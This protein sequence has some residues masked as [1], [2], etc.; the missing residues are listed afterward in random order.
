MP[1]GKSGVLLKE[2]KEI[3]KWKEGGGCSIY[4]LLMIK[5]CLVHSFQF[6]DE[7]IYGNPAI[8]LFCES[9]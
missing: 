3:L 2:K 8:K 4:I 1:P 9:C 6:V 7:R 5:G